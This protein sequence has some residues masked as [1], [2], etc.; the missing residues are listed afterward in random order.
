MNIVYRPIEFS[1]TEIKLFSSFERKQDV[2]DCRRKINGQWR[3]ISAPFIDDWNERD[4]AFLVKSLK[5]TVKA[6]GF[7]Y[8]AFVDGRLKGFVSVDGTPFGTEGQYADL[9]YLYVSRDMRGRGI[10][11]RLFE[12]AKEYARKTGAEKLYI[13]AHSA[14]E[15][16]AFYKAMGCVEASEYQ[17]KHVEKEPFDCQLEC[18][19]ND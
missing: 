4:Y 12:T 17:K 13:S 2:T 5:N 9:I 16:Q 18:V 11:R 15:T 7:V 8:G 1:E 6:G 14:V 10:G 19:L 3:I